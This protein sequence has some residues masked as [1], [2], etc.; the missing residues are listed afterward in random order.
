MSYTINR[1]HAS[2]IA[3]IV[4]CVIFSNFA[5]ADNDDRQGHPGLRAKFHKLKHQVNQNTSSIADNFSAI[6]GNTMSISDLNMRITELEDSAPQVGRTYVDIDCNANPNALLQPPVNGNFRDDTT[7]N[8][9]GPCNGPLYVTEDRVHFVG[10]EPGAAIVLPGG[11]SNPG[12]GAVFGDGA[13]DL[14]IQN[15]LIDAT[16]W[17]SSAVAIGTDAAGVYARNAFVR[18]IDT[19][20]EGGLYSI[21]PFRNAIIRTQGKVELVDFVH[22]GITVGDQSLVGARGPVHISSNVTDSGYLNAVEVY[23]S[24]VM[25]FRA[26]VTIEV[27]TEEQTTGFEPLAINVFRQSHI[28]IRDDG[29][30]DIR[31]PI[32]VNIQGSANIDHGNIV[33]DIDIGS[34]SAVT[35]NSVTIKGGVAVDWNSTLALTFESIVEGDIEVVG[36]SSLAME[37]SS[38]S[39]GEIFIAENSNV[40]MDASSVGE[41]FAENG[42]S[43]EVSGGNFDGAELFQGAIAN[44]FDASSFGNIRLFAPSNI[45]YRQ[46]DGFGSLN[47]NTI[48]L[49]GNTSSFID[50]AI[51]VTG[52]IDNGCLGNPYED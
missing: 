4:S 20:I 19:R 38:Q 15:L 36:G 9:I 37:Y 34:S 32:Q 24:G 25:D 18:I 30:V 13:H 44:F 48:Y 14:R 16:A 23:R 6:T 40:I 12:D 3:V 26:G 31:G 45:V 2:L 8:I 33:G 47:G 11:I 39:D 52:M 27:P 21:N 51:A 29:D 1:K 17:G 42:S 43:F 7:Y 49:C 46:E 41:I 5:V 22:N 28:R 35:L 10:I 50:P